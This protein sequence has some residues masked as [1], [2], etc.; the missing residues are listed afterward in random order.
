[1]MFRRRTRRPILER[2]QSIFFPRK[3]WRRG[4]E[5][6][7]HRMKRLPD[8]P[9][10]IAVGIA[11]GGFVSF[12]PFFGFHFVYAALV[13]WIFRG[14]IVA[15]LIGTAIGN[16]LTFP[17]I[18]ASSLGLGRW[19]LGVEGRALDFAQIAHAFSEAFGGLWQTMKSWVG[20]GESQLGRLADFFHS[21]FL[22][23]LVGGI[24]TGAACAVVTYLICR[25]I[26]AAYQSR[27]RA[28]LVERTRERVHAGMQK[29]AA[30]NEARE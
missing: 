19:M 15:G 14:N 6:L 12:S 3:G 26:V 21:V 28:R 7:G 23:Y 25:P 16:P 9:H 22:P 24:F 1:M 4:F 17:A 5:Y 8:T 29:V 10:R 30:R 2:L 13:A 27:R 20:M 11:A 18:A